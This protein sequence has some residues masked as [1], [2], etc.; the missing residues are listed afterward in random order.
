[1]GPAQLA[2]LLQRLFEDLL[3]S[4]L[5]LKLGLKGPLL[6]SVGGMYPTMLLLRMLMPWVMGLLR[7]V[8][9]LLPAVVWVLVLMLMVV[10]PQAVV[11]VLVLRLLQLLLLLLQVVVELA[12]H[13]EVHS[14]ESTE[15]MLGLEKRLP[16]LWQE[17]QL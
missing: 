14:V 6:V 17:K 4:V 8:V 15:L 1:M 11:M 12:S 3:A 9:L 5:Q 2:F 7:M 13:L 16:A 10:L